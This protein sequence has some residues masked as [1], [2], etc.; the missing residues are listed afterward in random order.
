MARII[1]RNSDNRVVFCLEDT[2]GITLT[3]TECTYTHTD[4][5]RKTIVLDVNS[6]THTV[7]EDVTAPTKFYG[8]CF[9]YIDGNW[10][11]D[12]DRVEQL[13]ANRTRIDQPLIEVE[14]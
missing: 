14:L 2:Q 10:A 9:T 11:I 7:I 5:D 13:N 12:T 1:V 3:E 4:N 6:T 8:N